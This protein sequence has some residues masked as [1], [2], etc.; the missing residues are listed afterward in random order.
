MMSIDP[1]RFSQSGLA[2]SHDARAIK[3]IFEL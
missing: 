2:A 3:L 1:I